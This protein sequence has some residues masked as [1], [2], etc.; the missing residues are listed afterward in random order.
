M[1]RC[2][3]KGCKGQF[4][5]K[6][7]LKR[8]LKIHANKKSHVCKQCSKRFTLAQYLEEH[9]FIHTGLKPFL[10]AIE[11]CNESFR[12]KGK[13]SIHRKLAHAQAGMNDGGLDMFATIEGNFEERFS[14]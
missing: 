9:E 8:H 2:D 14:E 1:F 7:S 11:G 13:L 5:T 12:Q 10:C 3:F 4:S 6:Y